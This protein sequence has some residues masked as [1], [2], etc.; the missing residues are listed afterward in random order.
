M[1]KDLGRID[2]AHLVGT[3]RPDA[4]GDGVWQRYRRQTE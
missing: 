3:A 1:T 2:Q 4:D